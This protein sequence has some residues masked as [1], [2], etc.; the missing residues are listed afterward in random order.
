MHQFFPAGGQLRFRILEHDPELTPKTV[1]AKK[2]CPSRKEKHHRQRASIA[3]RPGV[4]ARSAALGWPRKNPGMTPASIKPP[5]LLAP[6]ILCVMTAPISSVFD[7]N[8]LNLCYLN[9]SGSI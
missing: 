8:P 3:K 6:L 5:G 4:R 1:H 9:D 2:I 7:C